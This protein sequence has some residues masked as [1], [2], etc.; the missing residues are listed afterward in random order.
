MAEYKYDTSA[1]PA[2]PK[3]VGE[4]WSKVNELGGT[5]N[6]MRA[7]PQLFNPSYNWWEDKTYGTPSEVQGVMEQWDVPSWKLTDPIARLKAKIGDL[8]ELLSY[9]PGAEST[10]IRWLINNQI[11]KLQNQ[12]DYEYS[13][14]SARASAKLGAIERAEA[15]AGVSGEVPQ[16]KTVLER[17][18]APTLTNPYAVRFEPRLIENP[19][20]TYQQKV[21]PTKE[22]LATVGGETEL[23]QTPASS[24][25]IPDWMRPYLESSI[26]YGETTTP[27]LRPIGAQAQL[28]TQ[29]LGQMAGYE[30]WG[31][32]GAPTTFSESALMAMADWQK[33]WEPFINK[34]KALFP[35]QTTLGKRWRVSSQG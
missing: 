20:Y 29:Q 35:K 11:T 3:S 23:S 32:A 31:R 8:A 22:W 14:R 28:S 15:R 21:E 34:S 19:E 26:P 5:A 27:S 18:S 10:Y 9:F 16:Y 4:Y 1:S 7:Y 30:A 6:F 13:Q 17:V 2:Y 12:I 33:W 24:A 25:P